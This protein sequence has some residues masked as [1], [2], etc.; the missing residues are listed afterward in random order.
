MLE[1]WNP[2]LR[3][4]LAQMA[5]LARDEEAWWTAEMARLAPQLLLRGLPVRGGGR[6]SGEVLAV[7]V[8]R[9]GGLAP[10][11]QRRLLRHTAEELG[12]APDFAATEALRTLALSGRA[13]QKLE[14]AQGLAAERTQRELRLTGLGTRA[15][16]G[17]AESRELRTCRR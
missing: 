16:S 5:E 3:G 10:A 6:A 14:L 12:A 9:L 1:G 17:R 13:G 7:D 2:R 8:T 11:V 4:H 15:A